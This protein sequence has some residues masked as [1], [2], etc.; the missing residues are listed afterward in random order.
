VDPVPDL[1][2]LRKS[3]SAGN[4]TRAS[5]SVARS[6]DHYTTEAVSDS[7]SDTDKLDV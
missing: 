5:G 3:G 6:S 2:L 7:D 1:L 4:R